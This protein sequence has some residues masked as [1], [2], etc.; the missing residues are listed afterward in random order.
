MANTSDIVKE[1]KKLV[2]VDIDALKVEQYIDTGN[3]GLN[4][5]ITGDFLKGYPIGRVVELYGDPST[6]KS[7]LVAHA[8]ANAQKLGGI[9][10]LDD[11]EF[12]YDKFFGEMVGVDNDELIY[13]NS[14]TVEEHVDRVESLIK[15]IRKHDNAPIFIA[16]DSVAMLSTAHE[17]ESDFN[18]PDMQKAKLLRKFFR[19]KRQVFARQNIL[20]LVTNHVTAKIGVT[21]GRK[22]T[23]TGGSAIPFM[24][25]VRIE[26]VFKKKIKEDNQFIGVCTEAT[27]TKNKISPPFKYTTLDILFNKGVVRESGL[28]DVLVQA[29]LITQEGKKWRYKDKKYYGT[30]MDLL[31]KDY[32]NI[33]NAAGRNSTP[34]VV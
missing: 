33:L 1:A 12:T 24:G 9:A 4:Y 32:P 15:L 28:K 21:F 34:N 20:Y 30:E 2:G 14:E 17:M 29:G 7:L 5:I 26:L 16:L 11:S 13:F 25:S 23:T 8:I 22:K 27:A 3:Y 31:L 6:G 19:T 10:I 18:T